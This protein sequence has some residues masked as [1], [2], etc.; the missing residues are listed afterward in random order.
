MEIKKCYT[1]LSFEGTVKYYKAMGFKFLG[2]TDNC[3]CF[4]KVMIFRLFN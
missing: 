2:Y 3:A 4:D 1:K